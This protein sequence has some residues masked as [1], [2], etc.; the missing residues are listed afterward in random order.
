M[1][2]LIVICALQSLPSYA[3]TIDSQIQKGWDLYHS[4]KYSELFA[5]TGPKIA[6]KKHNSAWDELYG[7]AFCETEVSQ[8]SRVADTVQEDIISEPKN[9]HL[10][11]T[12]AILLANVASTSAGLRYV[13]VPAINLKNQALRYAL[14]AVALAPKDA[15][16]RFSSCYPPR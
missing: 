14:T 2:G 5:L 13:R 1:V 16:I 11:A 15:R 9:Y 8:V 3:D 12:G 6:Q 4:G 7:L 10:L